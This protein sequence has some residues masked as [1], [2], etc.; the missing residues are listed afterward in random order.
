LFSRCPETPPVEIPKPWIRF[1]SELD[2]KN[3]GEDVYDILKEFGC[4]PVPD[5]MQCP[6]CDWNR[7]NGSRVKIEEKLNKHM[8]ITHLI[9]NNNQALNMLLNIYGT[10]WWMEFKYKEGTVD[11][12]FTKIT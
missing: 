7:Y 3:G 12:T 1:G 2:Q 9:S 8:H 4:L 5:G 10:D 6:Y 11:W